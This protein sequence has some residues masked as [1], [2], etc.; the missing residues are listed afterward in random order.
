MDTDHWFAP[1][2]SK[3]GVNR[4]E[5]YLYLSTN[6]TNDVT[7]DIYNNN[8]LYTTVKVKKGAPQKV[9]IPYDF[10]V[11]TS[12]SETLKPITKGIYVKA[13][14]K[15]F[16]NYRFSVQSHAEIITSKGLAALGNK[17]YAAMAPQSTGQQQSGGF[18]SSNLNSTIGIIAT[19]DNTNVVVSNYNPNVK[20]SDGSQSPTQ[21]VVLKRGESYILEVVA[22]DEFSNF[23]GLIGAKIEADKPISVT[24]GNYNGI[25]SSVFDSSD[26]LMDQSVPVDRLGN[27]FVMVKGNA[28]NLSGM[29]QALV[30]A[31]EDNTTI[32]VNGVTLPNTLNESQYYVIPGSYYKD[33]GNGVYNMGI[34]TSK[35]VYVYQFLGGTSTTSVY[36]T[37]GMNFI[38]ALTC[39]LPNKIDEIALV[40]DMPY[41]SSMTF[42]TK[43][44]IIT[45]KG[46][47]VQLNGTPLTSIYGPF[48]VDGNPAWET[49]SI[50][51][52]QGNLT[53][54]SNKSV[55]AGIAAGSGAVGYG[56]YFSGFSSVPVITKSGDCFNGVKL[57]VDDTYDSYQW[58]INNNILAGETNYF[59]NPEKYG[60]GN[61]TVNIT[62]TNCDSKLT[63]P[64]NY[65]LCPPIITKDYTIGNCKT[66][67]ETP[68]FTIPT[69]Q[70][71][72]P[73][74][75]K[76][77]VQPRNGTVSINSTNGILT[78]TPDASITSDIADTFVYVIEGNGNTA[79]FQYFRVNVKVDYLTVKN[80]EVITCSDIKGFGT[81]NLN[82]AN[83]SD[84]S[85][86]TKIHFFEDKNDALKL[87]YA[88]AIPNPSSYYAKPKTLYALITNSY[89]CQAISEVKLSMPNLDTFQYESEICDDNLDGKVTVKLSDITPQ[90]IKDADLYTVVYSLATSP[91]V[92]LPDDFT[93]SGTT[94][95]Q[96]EV[97]SSGI[98]PPII[99]FID[100][101]IKNQIALNTVNPVAIC[102]NERNNTEN[103]NLADYT[104]LFTNSASATF[105]DNLQNA[106]DKTGGII[107]N[108]TITSSKTFYY[109]FENTSDCPAVG[110]L[111]IILKQPNVSDVLKDQVICK[112]T[113]T[114]LDAGSGFTGYKWST[115]ETTQVITNVGLGDYYVDLQS[116][117]CTYRQYVKVTASEVPV[118]NS[119][120]VEGSN[121]TIN[122]TG[123]TPPYQYSIDGN[124]WQSS[125]IFTNVP[126]GLHKGYVKDA[127]NCTPVEKEFLIVNLLNVIT[128]NGD[129]YNDKLDYSELKI[130]KDV[131]VEV[132]DRYGILIYKS[133]NSNYVWD[134]TQK[135][136]PVP[137]G[138]YW[139]ILKWIEPD[140]GIEKL[141]KGWVLVKNR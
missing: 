137:T 14:Q 35:N 40:N 60:N 51:D 130:Y 67:T 55:T 13:S 91:T 11:T 16:A 129:G 96:V 29:E 30:V 119:I 105:Y 70:N 20:F 31:T 75:T 131:S 2:A 39:F 42:I 134:G 50:N 85:N 49:Y 126:R 61:Y 68:A 56:G 98:C 95:V 21:N 88:N 108:Q 78:Y 109:R 117:G 106:K 24:N 80:A 26:I 5:S 18:F 86:I 101:K 128:P 133:N 136:R 6:Q 81:F 66:L 99:G 28:D 71:I 63:L 53:I 32:E 122:A 139:Y 76:I 15:I 25:Y 17:F 110:T 62:K 102:D 113:T 140:T 54:V 124:K 45:E 9:P 127:Y 7:V 72:V 43:L 114:T 92:P 10:M 97:R 37:G 22:N 52:V 93:F 38:P 19:E 48:P 141:Y 74:K 27:T 59:I 138:N 77:I 125:N 94:K 123:G 64:Y 120:N 83:V 107:P 121:V 12:R 115:G 132:F 135:G 44:N 8:T 57:E 58:Y 90:I 65:S 36:A 47:S 23:T 104:N 87:L 46:A 41:S 118:I 111:E 116:N 69:S 89:G 4:L 73:A 3:Q 33:Q 34:K 100:F 79:D 84:E 82:N 103:I 112:E 1:M